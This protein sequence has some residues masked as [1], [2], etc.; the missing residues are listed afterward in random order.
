[1]PSSSSS[2]DAPATPVSAPFLIPQWASVLPRVGACMTTRRAPPSGQTRLSSPPFDGFNLG[3]HVGDEP[4]AVSAHRA[5]LA[6]A[7]GV[8]PVWMNQVH[9]DRVV[10]LSRADLTPDGLIE[11]DGAWTDEPGLACTVM[12]A[13]CLPILLAVDE[14]RAVAALHAGWRGLAGRHADGTTGPGIVARGVSALCEGTGCEP[15]Q[16]QAWIGPCIGPSAFEVGADVLEGFG[17]SADD[18]GPHFLKRPHPATGKWWGHLAAL[19]HDRLVQAGIRR[20]S[21]GHWCTVSD[22]ARFFSFRRDRITGRQAALI[23]RC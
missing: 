16:I 1:M 12:V 20:V 10:R 5:A 15:A 21:G 8:R 14:G 17:V 9:G 19:A 18:P 23:W 11:A 22:S 7:F 6:S 2:S 3:A 4:G 13:D